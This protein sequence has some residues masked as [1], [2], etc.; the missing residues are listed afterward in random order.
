MAR[1]RRKPPPPPADEIDPVDLDTVETEAEPGAED[2]DESGSEGGTD[3]AKVSRRGSK[4]AEVKEKKPPKYGT[5]RPAA[6]GGVLPRV[7]DQL[8][9]AVAGTTRYKIGCRNYAPQKTRYILAAEGDEEG[10]VEC[11]L[12]ANGLD[13][14]LAGL[15]KKAGKVRADEV[16]PP[17]LVVT[18]L[19][20]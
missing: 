10:A 7:V 18:E 15:K 5:A 16:E 17:E 13:K 12:K 2:G 9:R 20:D 3:V 19:E 11:Y 1:E 4:G 14:L 6:T 8:E